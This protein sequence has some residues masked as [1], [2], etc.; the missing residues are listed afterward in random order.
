MAVWEVL[1]VSKAYRISGLEREEDEGGGEPVG[2]TER[3][4]NEGL[5]VARGKGISKGDRYGSRGYGVW[6]MTSGTGR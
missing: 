2:V 1:Y 4:K 5:G 6:S 3:E